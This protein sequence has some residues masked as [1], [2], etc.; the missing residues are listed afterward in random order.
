MRR[1]I[2]LPKRAL[3]DQP[4]QRV[5]ANSPQVFRREFSAQEQVPISMAVITA[6]TESPTPVA[7]GR[8][9]QAVNPIDGQ[10]IVLKSHAASAGPCSCVLVMLFS[11]LTFALWPCE[12]DLVL[13]GG[14]YWEARTLSAF[15]CTI[16]RPTA[17]KVENRKEKQKGCW[18]LNS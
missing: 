1:Q 3:S 11:L 2:D 14:M 12:S 15:D 9:P 13:A 16:Q 18:L 5:V 6:L 17:T 8:K 4:S 7:H 10:L